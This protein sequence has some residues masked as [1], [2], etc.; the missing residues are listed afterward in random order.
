MRICMVIEA[1]HPYMGGGQVHALELVKRLEREH[2]VEVITRDLVGVGRETGVASKVVRI[3]P[4]TKLGSALGRMLWI[5]RATLRILSRKYDLIH[6]H[7]NIAGYPAWLAGKLSRTPVVFTVHGSSLTMEKP[8]LGWFE[9][10]VEKTVQTRLR[11]DALISVDHRFAAI[12]KGAAV[13]P[14]GVDVDRFVTTRERR[15][16]FTY[17]FVGRLSWEKGIDVLLE[18][19]SHVADEDTELRI[20]GDGPMRA[21]LMKRYPAFRSCFVGPRYGEELVTEYRS[22]D[23]F[24]LPSRYEGQPLTVL[25]AWASQVPVIATHVGDNDRFVTPQNGWLI[26]AGSAEELARVMREARSHKRSVLSRMGRAGRT[27]VKKEYTWDRMVDR[28][29]ECYMNVLTVKY[30]RPRR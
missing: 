20:V 24:V 9:R 19:Y 1:W 21:E 23:V 3:G 26:R 5:A 14:N 22:A 29:E 25:E 18:A 27:L 17:L 13:I 4:C 16:K 15:E 12:A 6:A 28:T 10:F 11:Y 8:S 7:S 30:E 2:S